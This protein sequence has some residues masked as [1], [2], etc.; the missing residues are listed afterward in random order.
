MS[1]EAASRSSLDL[2]GRQL[3]L[4]YAVQATG[5]PTVVVLYSGRP[6]TIGWIAQHVPAI[7][8]VWLPGTQGGHAIADILFGDANPGGKLPITFPREVGQVPVYYN[9]LSTGRPPKADSKY[10]S[11]YLDVSPSPLFPFGYGLSY[12]RFRLS[13]LQ[14]STRSVPMN[15]QLTASVDVENVSDR[16]GD[17]VIQLY[18]R[19]VVASVAR[20]V[21]ELAG[22]ERL[23][24]RPGEKRTARFE[25]GPKQLGFYD[26]NVQFVVEPGEFQVTTGTSSEGGLTDHFEVTG[27][28]PSGK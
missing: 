18:I 1:G 20:P 12:S 25:L 13:N 10:T 24:L 19:D 26:R 7:L 8:E 14:L 15:G 22:F 17:E 16:V 21:K 9:H 27:A 2:P 3:E 4:V 5:T 28:G 23:T 6:L 11:K